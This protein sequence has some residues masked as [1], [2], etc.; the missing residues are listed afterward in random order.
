MFFH[1]HGIIGHRPYINP[2]KI[3]L[4]VVLVPVYPEYLGLS[5]KTN[6]TKMLDDELVIMKKTSPGFYISLSRRLL[7]YTPY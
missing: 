2:R 5:K 1:V 7:S 3:N 4:P 6:N